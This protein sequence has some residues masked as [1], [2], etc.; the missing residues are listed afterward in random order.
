[1]NIEQLKCPIG[2]FGHTGENNKCR[3]SKLDQRQVS[4]IVSL[5]SDTIGVNFH[6]LHFR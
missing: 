5:I 1:M 3:C 2:Q 6:K 4:E